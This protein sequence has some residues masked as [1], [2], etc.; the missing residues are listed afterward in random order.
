MKHFLWFGGFFL[1]VF[2]GD[3]VGGYV[4]KT[5]VKNSQ[6]R[7][8][9]LYAQRAEAEILLLGNSRGL[10]FY[11]PTIEEK[12]GQSTF[13]FSYNGLP[14]HVG[15]AMVMDYFEQYPMPKKLIIDVTLCDRENKELTTGFSNFLEVSPRLNAIIRNQI[16]D[17]W[18]G[19]QVS[20]LMRYNNEI[21]QRILYYRNRNDEDWLLD[22]QITEGIQA[23]VA[24]QNYELPTDPWYLQELADLTALAKAKD[25]Q[26]FLVVSPYYPNFEVKNLEIFKSNIE[27]ATQ[28]TVHDFSKSIQ[29]PSLFG[30]FLHINKAGSTVFIDLLKQQGIL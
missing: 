30:D 26:V 2:L 7:Y 8:S 28:M 16:P 24:N 19:T 29:D 4:L 23:N 12:T 18:W 15:A 14:M 11:Q 25:I 17:H 3:R 22:R 1:V 20:A 9:R 6:F 10:G 5:Q 27:T 13:N 21:F